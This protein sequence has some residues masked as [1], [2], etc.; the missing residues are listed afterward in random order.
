MRALLNVPLATAARLLILL[1]D[2]G[3]GPA[4]LPARTYVGLQH[5][6]RTTVTCGACLRDTK[7][8][9]Q[10][11]LCCT[12]KGFEVTIALLSQGVFEKGK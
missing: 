7:V 2:T 8:L 3:S 6:N 9:R 4:H 11:S 10:A 12:H 5:I 1:L